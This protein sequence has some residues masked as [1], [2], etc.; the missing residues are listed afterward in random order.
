MRYFDYL[1]EKEREK[2]FFIEPSE[3]SKDE[4]KEL[5]AYAL[6]ATM[7]MPATRE[8]IA[9]D[10]VS[11]KNKGLMSMVMCLE[12]A[13][14]DN[15]VAK[16]EAML[17]ENLNR[18]EKYINDGEIEYKD[19]PFIFIRV[20]NPKQ[21]SDIGKRIGSAISLITGFVFPKFSRDNGWNYLKELETLNLK[22]GKKLYAMI[23][24]ETPDIIY[25][26][27][28]RESLNEINKM[29]EKYND[30]VLNVRIGATDFSSLF[31]IRRSFDITVYDIKVIADCITDIINN[32]CRVD[33]QIVVSGVVWEYFT[34]SDRI[35]KPQLRTTP[36]KHKYGKGG[37]EV[38]SK[39]L[40]KYIDGLI[41]EIILDKANGLIGK[42]VIHPSHI[43]PVQSLYV[44][45]YEEYI[46]A[47]S[48]I[49][50]NDGQKGVIKSEYSNKMNEIKPH[51]SWANKILMRAKIYGVFREEQ[52]FVSLL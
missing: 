5:I 2:T 48:I 7:Y 41:H 45:S 22:L 4:P 38:R 20:R 33:R 46:D 25:W 47:L 30:L 13:I 31:G 21:I 24:L 12:D 9:L 8:N 26:E 3:I 40:D 49:Q 51:T 36:F 52:E 34:G 50:N 27:T 28:R 10:I 15:E 6:G 37:L 32:F 1:T 35:L 42:T 19:I 39:L 23:I 17:V 11:R 14:G 44:V 29:I 43:I 16:A 18:L